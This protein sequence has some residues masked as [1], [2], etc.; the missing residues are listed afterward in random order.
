M[1]KN[2]NSKLTPL[3]I[4]VSAV[5][6]SLSLFFGLQKTRSRVDVLSKETSP[7]TEVPAKTKKVITSI[8]NDPIMGNKDVAK[9][10]IVEFSDYECSYCK[11]FRN[12]TH[13]RLMEE[14]ID[15]EKA[16]LVFRDLPLGFHNPAAE[17]EAMAAECARDQG[18]DAAYFEY[19][20][21]IFETTPGNGKGIALEELGNLAAEM[22]LD[23]TKLQECIETKQF[24]DEIAQDV[25]DAAKAGINGTPG[26]VIGILSEDGSV[27]GTL[28][29][30]AQPF[31]VFQE[32]LEEYLN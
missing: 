29:S 24:K 5:L 27:E 7:T 16:I 1:N 22:G 2:Q 13:D 8:D 28:I 23:S 11:R 26:F 3:A 17:Q 4:I 32:V 25:A 18:N 6:I 21:K 10:A 19:H 12:Q 31:S 14:Y 9:V 20:D 30:G 15:T